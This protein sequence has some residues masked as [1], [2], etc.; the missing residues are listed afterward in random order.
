MDSHL[1]DRDQ[2]AMPALAATR[3]PLPSPQQLAAR[4]AASAALAAERETDIE[5]RCATALPHHA[6][7]AAQAVTPGRA[8]RQ[9]LAVALRMVDELGKVLQPMV[10]C[11]KGCDHC[12]HIR[13]DMTQLEAERL[14]QAIGRKPNARLRYMP[15]QEESVPESFG[16]HTPCP[17]LVHGEC[18]IYDHRPFACRKHHSLDIDALFCRLDLP[19]AFADCVPRVQ[20]GLAMLA[21]GAAMSPSMG[22]GDIRD[23][24][25][26][27]RELSKGPVGTI[28][29]LRNAL[30]VTNALP[31]TAYRGIVAGR[32]EVLD[33]GATSA[34]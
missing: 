2:P 34:G 15:H 27:P 29:T 14:G 17:F 21:Y 24:F 20:P 8:S 32:H 12:C 19:Q 5:R 6:A 31:D 23:W 33:G 25:P 22:M 18:S 26:G 1:S 28:R 30:A 9:R 16:Y 13:V 10:A 3:G 11:R 4:R 7:L